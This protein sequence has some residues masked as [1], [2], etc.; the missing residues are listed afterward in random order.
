MPEENQYQSLTIHRIIEETPDARTFILEEE[1]Q[2]IYEYKP[3]QFLTFNFSG[4][5]G[6]Q[7]R[8]YS[9]SSSPGLKEPLSITVKRVENGEF[10][11]YFVDHA[12]VGDVLQ[13]VGVGGLFVLP[14]DIDRYDQIFFLAAGSGIT[15]SFSLIK[16]ALAAH[17][18][19]SI[20]L[21]Y[22]NRSAKDTIFYESL[23]RLSIESHGRLK[24][25]FLFSTSN[26]ILKSRLNNS[27]L[28]AMLNDYRQTAKEKILA[29]ICGPVE[30]MD[31]V[32]ITL[33][34]DGIPKANI[35]KEIFTSFTPEI[36]ELPPDTLP[37]KVRIRLKDRIAEMTVQ[38]PVS[39]LH[40]AMK[41][42]IAL[43]YSCES[44]QCGSCAARCT[45]GHVWIA[46]NEILTE[47]ELNQGLILTC[48]GFPFGGDVELEY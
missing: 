13:C 8:S 43:P 28:S 11:R 27:L 33:L 41:E 30:Y 17:P 45:S 3:G 40:Q 14:E 4:V 23:K 7:R 22:S 26:N 20:V 46:Y 5:A 19:I 36:T 31:T 24:I 37:H 21:I 47:R 35:H 16:T 6:D 39:I 18:K 32:G 12:K 29:Y 2:N 10:S 15:P 34:T 25:D 1:G 42:G 44:G 38:H 9:I 48:Q